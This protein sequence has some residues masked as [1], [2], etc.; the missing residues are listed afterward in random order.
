MKYYFKINKLI[1]MKNKENIPNSKKQIAENQ[2]VLMEN[3]KIDVL[4]SENQ[5]RRNEI[6]A[7]NN[8]IYKSLFAFIATMG[9]LVGTLLSKDSILVNGNVA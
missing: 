5:N 6:I 2:N 7:T 4:I 3:Q 9:G 8:Q 1:T